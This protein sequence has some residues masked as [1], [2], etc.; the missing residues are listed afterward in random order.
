MT[1][2]EICLWC[3]QSRPCV[4]RI[5]SHDIY[6]FECSACAKKRRTAEVKRL[7]E[8]DVPDTIEEQAF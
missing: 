5:L 6:L 1:E 2:K 8:S 4:K 3:K 7:Q